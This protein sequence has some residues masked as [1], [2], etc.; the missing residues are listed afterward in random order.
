M[1]LA[2]AGFYKTGGTLQRD[3]PCYVPRQADHDLFEGL[4]AGEFCYVLTSRQMGKSSLMVRTAMRL[5]VEGM[6]VIVL[7]LTAIG[8]NVTVE[9]WYHDLLARMGEQLELE[10]EL[11]SYWETHA[12]VGPL[13][14][15]FGAIQDVVLRRCPGRIVIFVDEID[16]VRGLPFSTD[17]FFA[18]IRECY[19]RRAEDTELERL[20]FCLL[21]VATP[22]DLI[23][24]TRTTPFNIG[25]C[26]QLL[27]FTAAE[28]SVLAQGLDRPK[29]EAAC[30]LERALHST[31]GHPYLTQRLC[32]A[33]AE[34][35]K[36]SGAA[37]VDRICANLFLSQRGRQL[38]DNLVFV[39]ERLLNQEVDRAAVLDLYAQVLRGRRVP[40]DQTNSLVNVLRLAGVTRVERGWLRVR[41]PIYE[42]VFDRGWVQSN[43]PDAELRRQRAAFRRGL[44]RGG[45]LA[46]GILA[47]ITAMALIIW[48]QKHKA[49]LA[50]A[51][52]RDQAKELILEGQSA[53]T[54]EKWRDAETALREAK[55]KMGPELADLQQRTD[56]MLS[57][58]RSKEAAHKK[59]QDKYDQF[60][61][62]R[63]DALFHATLFT[64]RDPA[65]NMKRTQEAAR[66]ALKLFP[67]PAS[68]ADPVRQ[69]MIREGCYEMSLILAEAVALAV[70]GQE[71]DARKQQL[72]HALRILNQATSLGVTTQA[73]HLY[74]ARY[75]SKLGQQGAAEQERQLADATRPT[76]ALDYFLSGN[77]KF[78][79]GAS[80][81]ARKDLERAVGLQPNHFWAKY[82]L[83]ICYLREHRPA[84]A[85]ASL[86]ACLALRSDIVGTYLLRGFASAELQEYRD[87]EEDYKKALELDAVDEE[88]Y[89]V[90]VNW[91]VMSVRQDKVEQG[92]KYFREAV[93]LKPNQFQA[94]VNMAQGFQ[95]GKECQK[96]VEQINKAIDRAPAS[97]VAALYRIRAQLH[98]ELQD[99]DSALGD[100]EMAIR[101]VRR[102]M[103][104]PLLGASTTGLLG[105]MLGQGTLLAASGLFPGRLPLELG[106]DYFERGRILHLGK[107]FEQAVNAYD[108]ALRIQPAYAEAHRLRGRALLDL[109]RYKEAIEA[110]DQYLARVDSD[111][112][113]YLARAWAQAKL[114]NHASAIEDY[115]LAL[116]MKP[117]S[118]TLSARGW[119]H[120]HCNVP[121][122]AKSDFEAAIRL[123]PDSAEALSGLGYAQVM[124]GNYRAGIRDANRALQLGPKSTRLLYTAARTFAQAVG[125]MDRD[126]ARRSR[127]ALE[128]RN[129][130][131]ARAMD[132]IRSALRLLSVTER[133]KF[134]R[135]IV[136]KDPA[137]DPIRG[138]SG[139]ARREGGYSKP[140]R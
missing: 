57:E 24:D 108:E 39:R 58:V 103:A 27:D 21:G 95:K 135:D 126:P 11:E 77:E 125:K 75:L 78:R 120:L 43:M 104:F 117:D 122:F 83:A 12:R 13:T 38:D 118:E 124:L 92:L 30:L 66:E 89:A 70:P 74:R 22:S 6:V 138:R 51:T 98:R 29:Q 53:I 76:S 54:A 41:N 35:H 26:I 90:Y 48:N 40:D 106:E 99:P 114:G 36:R 127:Q 128:E 63:D 119:L 14:R 107:R 56:Q 52:R 8:R 23:R 115:T 20:T 111:R 61:K 33:I 3:A 96:A 64:G 112:P 28:A 45:A 132:L 59:E 67:T 100:L 81:S 49:D 37:G 84:E 93:S 46:V 2:Y 101:A 32:Q 73:Y 34:D 71:G 137:L 16:Y 62:L 86:N 9:Q 91:G 42:H 5:R 134:W 25:R 68:F 72:T 131:Q 136:Q 116:K 109:Q 4:K 18:A 97:A 130:F 102:P 60:L 50:L 7:D 121:N 110:F 1:S 79:R 139:W 31:G 88:K 85:K 129:E 133:S 105:S 55:A 82:F 17:E 10:D 19:N 69:R 123:N 65:T 47:V 80:E 87:A 113:T 15:W 140:A 44:L 94:Y